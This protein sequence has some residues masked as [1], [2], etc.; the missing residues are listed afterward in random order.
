MRD[1]LSYYLAYIL[2]S[3]RLSISKKMCVNMLL[4]P[5]IPPAEVLCSFIS[6]CESKSKFHR[7][8]GH[9]GPEGE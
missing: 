1:N 5:V 6:R 7:R 2:F 3:Y 9:E 8:T 4:K